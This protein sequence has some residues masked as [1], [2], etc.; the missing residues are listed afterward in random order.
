MIELLIVFFIIGIM[1][2]LLMPALHGA[3][4]AANRT[5]CE[6]NLYQPGFPI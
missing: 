5:V 2:A 4:E 6:N 3:R 1:M